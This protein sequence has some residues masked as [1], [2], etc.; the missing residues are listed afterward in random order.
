[1]PDMRSRNISADIFKAF[2]ISFVLFGHSLSM[3]NKIR[4]VTWDSSAVNI[5]ITSFNMPAFSLV[6]GYF[7][8]YSL[9]RSNSIIK[10][11]LSRLSRILPVLFVWCIIPLIISIII[12]DCSLN[13]SIIVRLVYQCLF[14]GKLWYLASYLTCSLICGVYYC[15]EVILFK[16]KR[17]IFPFMFAGI[18]LLCHFSPVSFGNT[19]F[20]LPFFMVGYYISK[21]RLLNN[22]IFQ[23]I[24]KVF[25]ILFFILLFYYKPEISFYKLDQYILRQHDFSINII[26]IYISI[27]ISTMRS[28][29]CLYNKLSYL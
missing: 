6:S 4:E 28:K 20:L 18:I 8:F 13:V 16:N 24:Y 29:F 19:T 3:L 23:Y 27:Y 10:V 2:L 5:F 9:I 22:R 11:L 14:T 7:I 1:M 17:V 12:S 26:I 25:G 21:F 15:C